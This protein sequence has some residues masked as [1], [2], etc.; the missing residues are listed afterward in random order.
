MDS[1]SVSPYHEFRAER[2]VPLAPLTTL[3]LGGH[4]EFYARV[5]DDALRRA[6]V[7]RSR[8]PR[9]CAWRRSNVVVADS[10]VSGL[11]CMSAPAA[12][13]CAR[14]PES[15][16]TIAAASRGCGCRAPVAHGV[17]ACLPPIPLAGAT[18]IQNV[19]AYGVEIAHVLEWVLDR[20]LDVTR[21]A[22]DC[23]FGYRHSR[24]GRAQ[25]PRR[26]DITLRL[27]RSEGPG[28]ATRS[29][30]MP[31]GALPRVAPL[32]VRDAV[33]RPRASRRC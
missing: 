16:F 23:R 21:S 12:W 4:A 19:G 33:P 27:A 14:M 31:C 5:T 10:G 11:S 9:T 17:R 6:H 13:P 8:A 2:N 15:C 29:S 28:F 18:P 24:F 1:S 20:T 26:V 30:P 32:T 25:S 7:A 3:A 22:G